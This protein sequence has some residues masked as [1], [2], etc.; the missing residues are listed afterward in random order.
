[1]TLKL[2]ALILISFFIDSSLCTQ[3]ANDLLLRYSKSRVKPINLFSGRKVKGIE[4][5]IVGRYTAKSEFEFSV[6]SD[7]KWRFD[8]K[9]DS[10]SW[11]G[12]SARNGNFSFQAGK[13][14]GDQFVFGHVGYSET[15][16]REVLAGLLFGIQLLEVP[17]TINRDPID[18]FLSI[19]SL[20]IDSVTETLS[21]TG[22]VGEKV[23]WTITPSGKYKVHLFGEFVWLP[24]NGFLIE[25]SSVT[26]GK[27]NDQKLAPIQFV[28][29]YE[30]T[31]DGLRPV[32]TQRTQNNLSVTCEL[33]ELTEVE[34]SDAY[35]W[36]ESIGLETPKNP[37]RFRWI[38]WS[39]GVLFLTCGV[40]RLWPRNQ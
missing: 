23:A 17:I 21:A 35:Y 20:S 40:V 28:V 30:E 6:F 11:Q 27:R 32:K 38:W 24:E 22:E 14:S 3:N 37:K 31:P 34:Q 10:P 15:E 12:V 39:L 16:R 26:F 25:E 5:R 36:P 4:T 29:T 13:K 8:R 7:R 18:E 1:M 19:P 2:T 33:L 9:V